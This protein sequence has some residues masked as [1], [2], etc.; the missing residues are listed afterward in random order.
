M[1]TPGFTPSQMSDFSI[2]FFE[3]DSL[4]NNIVQQQSN[5][6]IDTTCTALPNS[7]CIKK[8]RPSGDLVFDTMS[9]EEC[10]NIALNEYSERDNNVIHTKAHWWNP[11][12]ISMKTTQKE[13]EKPSSVK[14]VSKAILKYNLYNRKIFYCNLCPEKYSK[15]NELLNHDSTVH[16]DV[17]K[18]FSCK[19][20]GK[21]FL[22]IGRLEVHERVHR[23]KLFQCQLCQKK[24]VA[25]KTLNNH[26]NIHIGLYN[27]QTC[28]YKAHNMRNLKVHENT[29]STVKNYCCN[30]C[31]KEFTMLS[32]L[33]RHNRLVHQKSVLYRCN[34]CDFSTIQPSNLKY[35]LFIHYYLLFLSIYSNI[36]SL[37][38]RHHESTHSL[39]KFICDRCGLSYKTKELLK[40]HSKTHMDLQFQCSLCDKLFKQKLSLKIHLNNVHE[41]INKKYKCS[42]CQKYFMSN[43]NLRRHINKKVCLS[44]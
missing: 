10:T 5:E 32:S 24:F 20:C 26:L 43:R 39:L 13:N 44:N 23:E 3:S 19:T 41:P 14:G 38:F 9:G 22:N 2:D 25:Q 11:K 7:K 37:Y 27:C 42:R 31:K 17:P 34:Q 8:V 18:K 35:D 30:D 36:L 40:K 4:W 12:A 29:H 1:V 33:R 15:F 21:L 6:G 16:C 28:G